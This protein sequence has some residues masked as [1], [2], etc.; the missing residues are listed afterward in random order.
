MFNVPFHLMVGVYQFCDFNRNSL[1]AGILDVRRMLDFGITVGLGQDKLS[2][3]LECCFEVQLCGHYGNWITI[4]WY[5]KH[6]WK[7]HPIYICFFLLGGGWWVGV[8]CTTL[9]EEKK[10]CKKKKS[11]GGGGN[12]H[13]NNIDNTEDSTVFMGSYETIGS[14]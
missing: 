9:G 7:N 3:S 12:V 2:L 8:R 13:L 14:E 10:T 11:G 5:L 6:K 1:I 4:Q